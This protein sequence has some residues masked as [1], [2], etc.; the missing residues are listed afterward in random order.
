M[1]IPL[2]CYYSPDA[3]SQYE[4]SSEHVLWLDGVGEFCNMALGAS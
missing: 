2:E 4:N 3:Y 1:D